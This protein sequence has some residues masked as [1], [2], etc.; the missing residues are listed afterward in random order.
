MFWLNTS[1][2]LLLIGGA[3]VQ[4]GIR[5]APRR[6]SPRNSTGRLFLTAVPMPGGHSLRIFAQDGGFNSFLGERTQNSEESLAMPPLDS[7]P[8]CAWVL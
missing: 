4:F 3:K 5:I 2:L 6:N 8:P 7:L 1:I